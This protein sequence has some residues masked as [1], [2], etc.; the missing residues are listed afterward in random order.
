M[1]PAYENFS[2]V[3][4]VKEVSDSK[5]STFCQ[6]GDLNKVHLLTKIKAK[7]GKCTVASIKK[8][9]NQNN[10]SLKNI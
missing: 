5:H 10:A 1:I 4:G 6:K 8:F 2:V 3:V 7:Y 9:Q